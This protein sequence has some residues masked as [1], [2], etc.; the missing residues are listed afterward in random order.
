L[1]ALAYR[2]VLCIL[3]DGEVVTFQAVASGVHAITYD[4]AE[5][6]GDYRAYRWLNNPDQ[7]MIAEYV[8]Q[9]YGRKCDFFG[10]LWTVAGAISMVWM[11]HPYRLSSWKLFC[12]ENL[13]GYT[14]FMGRETDVPNKLPECSTTVSANARLKAREDNSEKCP[15]ETKSSVSLWMFSVSLETRLSTGV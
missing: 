9:N 15:D 13:A 10:Y 11:H 2:I 14:C 12:W 6:I 3:E 7:S 8:S 1:E 5:A 4:N